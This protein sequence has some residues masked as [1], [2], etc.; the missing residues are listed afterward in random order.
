MAPCD[1]ADGKVNILSLRRGRVQ[2]AMNLEHLEYRAVIK[3]LVK[4][5]VTAK[6]IFERMMAVYGGTGPAFSTVKKWTSEFKHGR[7]SIEDEPRCGRPSH[8]VT[9][10][11]IAKVEALLMKDKHVNVRE[12]ALRCGMSYGS[13]Y[14]IIRDELA[15]TKVSDRW[16]PQDIDDD[17]YDSIHEI[18]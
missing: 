17:D 14:S 18:F 11:A 15:L 6:A 8:I 12:V 4:E 7:H 13:A 2:C 3:F 10:E 9:P 1:K 16:V 5:G